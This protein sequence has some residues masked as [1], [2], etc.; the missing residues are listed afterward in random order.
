MGPVWTAISVRLVSLYAQQRVPTMSNN[1]A[2]TEPALLAPAQAKQDNSIAQVI[3]QALA[4]GYS[5]DH[6]REL[7]AFHRE[8]K[9]DQARDAFNK[10]F[11]DFKAE[12]IRI[13]RD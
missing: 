6:M 11:T 1:L 13:V 2:T 8:I 5:A 9:A 12:D 3:Q 7:Y 10:A 4:N